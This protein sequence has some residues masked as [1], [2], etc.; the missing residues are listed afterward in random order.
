MSSKS[1]KVKDSLNIESGGTASENGDVVVNSNRLQFHNGSSA[2]NI[3]TASS[4]DTLT[5]KTFD[6][7]GSGNSITN[8]E[9]ADIKAGAAIALNKLAAATASR[10]LVSDASGFVSAATTTST[11]IGYVNGVTSA[12]QTQL[13]NKASSSDL[14]THTGAS[15]GVHGVSGSVVGTSDSQTL[16]NKTISGASNTISNIN[17]ATQVTG[18]LPVANRNSGTSASASTFW[19]G[20]ASWA[21]PAGAAVAVTSK[22]TTYTATTADDVIL[23]DT[24]G[25][26]W[27]LTLY[28]SSSNSGRRLKVKK[29]TSDNNAL[30]IDGNSSETIDGQ[31]TTTINT[32]YECIT[33]INDGTNWHIESRDYPR[34]AVA[35]TPT[36]SAGW[37][38]VAS[39]NVFY[40]RLGNICRIYGTF[41][42]GTVAASSG[43]I[44]LP[45]GL[46]IDTTLTAVAASGI[47]RAGMINR[48]TNGSNAVYLLQKVLAVSTGSTTT[49]YMADT[50]ASN[51]HTATTVSS[52]FNTGEYTTFSFEVP[53][54]GWK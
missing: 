12:I 47:L 39:S 43:T 24:S 36:Y 33:L 19:R 6:A 52:V 7:D 13:N 37:G 8:I 25:G 26:A 15:T 11:E 3:V 31:A 29:T 27:T 32:Q 28:A 30:T 51:T 2:V 10:A 22:T 44:S 46:N 49:V 23:V 41:T 17:L 21:S 35:Y 14:T 45:S 18:N 40:Q 5:G 20:D 4:T 38:T 16:T 48:I 53:I 1:F 9:N 42:L 50:A 54:S 34:A